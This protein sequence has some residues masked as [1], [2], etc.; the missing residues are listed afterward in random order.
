M[1]PSWMGE[2]IRGSTDFTRCL[3]GIVAAMA[4]TA[5]PSVADARDE[6][7]TIALVGDSTVTEQAGWGGA[8]ADRFDDGV[9]VLNF[10][11]SGRSSRSWYAE[12]RLPG[13]LQAKP[14]YALIQ[15]GHNDLP[16][17]GAARET[18]PNTSYREYLRI[19]VRAFRDIG[20]TPILV[21]PV[22]RRT[23]DDGGRIESVLTPW[24]EAAG[25]VAR[26]MDA[27]FIDL[28]GA[29]VDYHNEL[30]P[31][32]SMTF[33][34]RNGDVTH[35]NRRGAEAIADLVLKRLIPLAGDLSV[36]LK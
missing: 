18:D 15:F 3:A 7:V 25:A 5:A 32:A 23:F 30:G 8:F 6:V 11:V 9:R 2:R 31:E 1:Y 33:N 16:G 14:D 36:H 19:Y 24:A 35:F 4:F 27:P 34:P 10:A 28:H 12:N 13:V 29:S 26:E 20:A 21:S 17:K 22:T